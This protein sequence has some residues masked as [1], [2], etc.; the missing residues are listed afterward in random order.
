MFRSDAVWTVIAKSIPG[1]LEGR[2]GRGRDPSAGVSQERQ[3]IRQQCCWIIEIIEKKVK[4]VRG[5]MDGGYVA[6]LV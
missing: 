3:K 1:S 2:L 6:T 4:T 5:Y